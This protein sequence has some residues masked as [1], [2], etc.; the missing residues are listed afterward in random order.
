MH[1][2]SFNLGLGKLKKFRL[3]LAALEAGDWE[4]A[5]QQ[6]LRSKWVGQVGPGRSGRIAALYRCA[7]E[8]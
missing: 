6:A 5:A 3:M 2:P 8:R 7:D 4:R 1:H